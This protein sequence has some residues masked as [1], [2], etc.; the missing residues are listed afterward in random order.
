MRPAPILPLPRACPSP[1]LFLPTTSPRHLFPVLASAPT[2]F[3]PHSPE[4]TTPAT[5]KSP[6][7]L[8]T[9]RGMRS[10]TRRPSSTT[11]SFRSLIPQT[12]AVQPEAGTRHPTPPNNRFT[13]EPSDPS[14][15]GP[16]LPPFQT[17]S[18]IPHSESSPAHATQHLLARS[19][20]PAFPRQCTSTPA[21]SLFPHR[22]RLCAGPLRRAIRAGGERKESSACRLRS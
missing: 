13:Q 22:R 2:P 9:K 14:H 7:W 1:C 11:A 19:P 18:A 12:H 17:S 4:T 20:P 8:T 15:F 6:S 16:P 21:L 3:P 5:P 10:A